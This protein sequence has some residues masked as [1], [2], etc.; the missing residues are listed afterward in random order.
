MFDTESEQSVPPPKTFCTIQR[1]CRQRSGRCGKFL[2][3]TM[4]FSQSTIGV[5]MDNGRR[6][7]GVHVPRVLICQRG[8]AKLGRWKRPRQQRGGLTLLGVDYILNIVYSLDYSI[9]TQKRRAARSNQ[10]PR[11]SFR[12]SEYR[13]ASRLPCLTQLPALQFEHMCYTVFSDFFAWPKLEASV[14][15]VLFLRLESQKG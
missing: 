12:Q 1:F 8:P 5:V 3:L 9:Q 14:S 4:L 11:K 6:Q 10:A 7:C 13:R 2:R 15:F